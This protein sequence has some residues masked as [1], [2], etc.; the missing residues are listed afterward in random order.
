MFD[1]FPE[2]DHGGEH[3]IEVI[4]SI[5]GAWCVVVEVGAQ[6]F[7]AVVAVY[8]ERV[9]FEADDAAEGGDYG[10]HFGG[11]DIDP[12]V[13]VSAAR[14]IVATAQGERADDG[15]DHGDGDGAGGKFCVG[16]GGNW[17]WEFSVACPGLRGDQTNCN[18][19]A[20]DGNKL[21][22]GGGARWSDGGIF[23]R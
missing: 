23:N 4:F 16:E 3:V 12:G 21:P 22:A 15:E 7:V 11:F 8:P 13:E 18:K 19:S 10:G 6:A 9:L 20:H 17:G 5:S 2:F 1:S 14:D